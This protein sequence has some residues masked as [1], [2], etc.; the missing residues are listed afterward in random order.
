[1]TPVACTVWVLRSVLWGVGL[2]FSSCTA[3]ACGTAKSFGGCQFAIARHS[4]LAAGGNR[5]RAVGIA[6]VLD[7]LSLVG[8]WYAVSHGHDASVF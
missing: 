6:E 4:L 3:C 5:G 8:Q 2:L 7:L 1:M